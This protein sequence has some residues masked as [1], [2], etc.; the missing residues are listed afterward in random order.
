MNWRRKG[1]GNGKGI[2][3]N[4]GMRQK[5]KAEVHEVFKKIVQNWR[6]NDREESSLALERRERVAEMVRIRNTGTR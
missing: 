1:E 2:W 4:G 5:W 6:Q 3:S